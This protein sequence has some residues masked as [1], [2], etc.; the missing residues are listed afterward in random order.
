MNE[1]TNKQT[2]N[3]KQQTANNHQHPSNPKTVHN[4]STYTHTQA[5]RT[6][7]KIRG[8]VRTNIRNPL[9]YVT[10]DVVQLGDTKKL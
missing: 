1:R 7:T 4:E 5:H 9:R 8:S 10:I 6:A 3:D 2:I